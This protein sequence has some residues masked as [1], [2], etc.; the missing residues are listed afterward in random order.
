LIPKVTLRLKFGTRKDGR[1]PGAIYLC[2]D[3]K[4]KNFV[5]GTFEAM[6]EQGNEGK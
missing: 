1:L 6:V 5:A 2:I 4:E 3:D